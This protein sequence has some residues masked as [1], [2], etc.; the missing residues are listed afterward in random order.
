MLRKVYQFH[1]LIKS[2]SK[3]KCGYQIEETYKSDG[4]DKHIITGL[5]SNWL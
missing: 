2:K 5:V 4:S 1:S 3:H